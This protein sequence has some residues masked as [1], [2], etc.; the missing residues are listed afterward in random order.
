MKTK[1]DNNNNI[2][3]EN[4]NI[5]IHEV[6]IYN[7]NNIAENKDYTNINNNTFIGKKRR[8]F[9][10]L[11]DYLLLIG[12]IYHGKK[13]KIIFM[14]RNIDVI[15]KLWLETKSIQ[16]IKHRIKNLTC[17]KAPENVIKKYKQL[18][19]SPPTKDE[20]F[21]FLKAIQWFGTKKKWN[22]ISRYFLPDR[23]AEYLEE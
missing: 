10:Y 11:H 7:T 2:N 18:S 3:K 6:P 19:E 13:Y 5:N 14:I 8:K 15:Q 4:T 21:T 16:E 23:T 1:T 20:F 22:C 9:D 12:L 17:Y